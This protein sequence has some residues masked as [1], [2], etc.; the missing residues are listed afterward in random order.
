MVAHT[1]IGALRMHPPHQEIHRRLRRR[2]GSKSE[3]TVR[4]ALGAEPGGDDGEFAMSSVKQWICCLEK[5]ER[6]D[7]VYLKVGRSQ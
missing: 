6:A 1:D 4:T 7:G 5:D 2:I 3:G